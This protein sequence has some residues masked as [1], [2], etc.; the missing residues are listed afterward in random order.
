[1]SDATLVA[2]LAAEGGGARIFRS[3]TTG[4]RLYR[5]V[6]DSDAALFEDDEPT[7][8]TPAPRGG[9]W[10]SA[11]ALALADVPWPWNRFHP[12]EIHPEHRREML[13]LKREK[14]LMTG[15][16]NRNASEWEQACSDEQ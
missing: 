15:A 2:N 4:T 12:V 3:D 10:R 5:A 16:A 6:L 14:D 13:R 1:M 8:Q 9:E 7:E 11:L